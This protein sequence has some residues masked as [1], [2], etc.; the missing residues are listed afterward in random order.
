MRL[1]QVTLQ[2]TEEKLIYLKFLISSKLSTRNIVDKIVVFEVSACH[3][4]K[5]K[6]DTLGH[7]YVYPQN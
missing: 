1:F 5:F 6:R 3:H 4:T 2:R 7:V